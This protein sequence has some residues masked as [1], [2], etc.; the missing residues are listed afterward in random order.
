MRPYSISYKKINEARRHD[1]TSHVHVCDIMCLKVSAT[2][3][4]VLHQQ[5]FT[6]TID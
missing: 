2:N 4:S 3:Q 6:G 5:P 1:V